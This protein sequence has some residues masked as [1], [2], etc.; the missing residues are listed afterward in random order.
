MLLRKDKPEK[1]LLW[2]EKHNVFK[3]RQVQY[4]E[5][6]WNTFASD[7][8]IAILQLQLHHQANI[9]HSYTKSKQP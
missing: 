2:I 1:R 7:E 8:Y 6:I 3:Q 5:G 4:S 9:N